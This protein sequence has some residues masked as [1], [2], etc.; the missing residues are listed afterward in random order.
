[1][2][3]SHHLK[4]P[5]ALDLEADPILE[6]GLL[7]KPEAEIQNLHNPS[8]EAASLEADLILEADLVWKQTTTKPVGYFTTTKTYS[9][10]Q[11][12]FWELLLCSNQLP[13]LRVCRNQTKCLLSSTSKVPAELYQQSAC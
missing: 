12:L 4:K 6:A 5:R 8:L 7:K 1:M 2:C 13:N 11:A 3:R 10:L 9:F